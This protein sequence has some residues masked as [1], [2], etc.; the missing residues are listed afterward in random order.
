M[1]KDYNL[2]FEGNT[3]HIQGGSIH[4]SDKSD[5]ILYPSPHVIK[6]KSFAT[7]GISDIYPPPDDF[8]INCLK[9]FV[10]DLR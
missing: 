5:G 9:R 2:G 8:L 3:L 1:E 7:T 10:V 4:P 6:I